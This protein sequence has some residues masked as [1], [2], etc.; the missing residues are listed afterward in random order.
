LG[1]LRRRRAFGMTMIFIVAAWEMVQVAAEAFPG[2]G[3]L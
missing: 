2:I 3:D 1:E